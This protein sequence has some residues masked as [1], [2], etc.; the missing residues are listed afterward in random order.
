M[1]NEVTIIIIFLILL[2]II[3]GSFIIYYIYANK[4]ALLSP[5]N[6]FYRLHFF[7]GRSRFN[8]IGTEI[9]N[10]AISGD[11]I[12]MVF[13]SGTVGSA[14]SKSLKQYLELPRPTLNIIVP[15]AKLFLSK[16]DPVFKNSTI[17]IYESSYAL[18]IRLMLLKPDMRSDKDDGTKRM[19]G[20]ILFSNSYDHA[21]D[22]GFY[23]IG[24][25]N[26]FII[27]LIVKA[28]LE[29]SICYERRVN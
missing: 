9:M 15:D 6:I 19:V 28:I 14:F 11:T 1:T 13:R 5:D 22:E 26:V 4:K 25:E 17:N 2:N 24:H 27:D 7:K 29:D 20:Y 18:N 8:D 23:L 10:G 16:A 21:S 3:M 12:Y